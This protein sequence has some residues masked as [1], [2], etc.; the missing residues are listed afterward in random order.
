ML[1]FRF[2]LFHCIFIAATFWVPVTTEALW[3]GVALY[4]V[5][6][7]G[8]TAGYHRYFSHRTYK[9]SRW[10]AFI[11]ACIAQSSAQRGVIWWAG[12]H[13]HHHRFSDKPEDLHSPVAQNLFHAHVGWL[14]EK[15][16]YEVRKNVTDL[17]RV[18]ELLWL[19]KYP[20][21]PA[22]VLG[23]LCWLVYDWSGL[24]Y[25]FGLSTIA[26]FHGTFVINSLTHV[27]GRQ[28]F[29]TTDQSRNNLLLALITMGEGWHNNHHRYMKSTRQGFY[30]W[31][32]DPTYY[33]LLCLSWFGIVWDLRPVPPEILQE[34][35][36]KSH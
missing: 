17:Q 35:L 28:R 5:R 29:Q 36:I 8:V 34:G 31:E 2:V 4:W 21:T 1:R 25:G 32:V 9:T 7:F 10:F 12:N 13:R 3:L 16:S 23:V 26:L 30:W 14:W 18:P 19:D 6:M 24:V 22:I 27:W 15:E 33:I 20:M 11:L